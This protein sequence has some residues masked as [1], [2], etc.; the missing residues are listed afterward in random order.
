[1]DENNFY[2]VI[3]AAGEGKRMKSRKAKV[4]HKV[5]GKELIKWVRDAAAQADIKESCVVVGHGED[6]VR[7]SLQDTVEYAVQAEQ[8]GTGHAVKSASDF[9]NRHE[10]HILVLCGDVPLITAESIK[11]ICSKHLSSGNDATIV[12]AF[13]NDPKGYGRIDR[14]GN[15]EFKAIVEDRDCNEEQLLIK[16][17]N[18]GIYCF[19]KDMLVESLD[20]L[21]DN[22]AQGEYYLTDVPMILKNKGHKVDTFIIDDNSE[23]LGINDRV[24]LA[25]ANEILRKRIIKSHMMNGVTFV[26]PNS[27]YLDGDISIEPD[28]IVYP[29]CILESGTVIGSECVIG[30]NSRIVN[31]QI[32]N[33]TEINN[34]VIMD[35]KVG[36]NTKVGPFAYIRPK[37]VVGDNIKV[38]DFVELKNSTIG[39]NTKIS[40]LTYVGDSDIGKNV[41]IGCGVVTVNYDGKS[42]YRTT[43]GDNSFV[44]CN[45]NLVSPVE[46]GDD[47]YIAAGSTITNNVPS[48]SMAIARERQTIKEDWVIN[49]RANNKL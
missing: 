39:D 30:P 45:V 48:G 21:K 49:R 11:S 12:T 47:T 27:S 40:H 23:I 43:V 31:S 7:E 22:N 15:G 9:I 32:G 25:E 13:F 35:S 44:G 36:N 4:L 20:E 18:A 6:Q 24:Q 17:C 34:S 8:K 28:T 29:N 10:G 42:K 46:I 3:L 19:R 33:N 2:A 37:N 38:G 16:E 26:D 1:M 14:S 5:C 41:N